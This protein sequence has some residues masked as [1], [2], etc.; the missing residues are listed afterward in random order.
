[1]RTWFLFSWLLV[2]PLGCALATLSFVDRSTMSGGN[3]VVSLDNPVP[4]LVALALV[5][6]VGLVTIHFVT[7]MLHSPARRSALLNQQLQSKRRRF[8]DGREHP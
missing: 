2:F 3:R 1:M 5:V 4:F 6:N 8:R 7:H